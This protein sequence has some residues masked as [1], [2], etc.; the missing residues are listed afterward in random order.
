MDMGSKSPPSG[1]A[2]AAVVVP[3]ALSSG[4]GRDHSDFQL[5][6]RIHRPKEMKEQSAVLLN[7]SF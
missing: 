5:G 2:D 4:L 6:H 3:S 1:A 7:P